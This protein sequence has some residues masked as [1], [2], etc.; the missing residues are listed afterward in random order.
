[1]NKEQLCAFVAQLELR[2]YLETVYTELDQQGYQ[3]SK[4]DYLHIVIHFINK[5]VEVDTSR[6]DSALSNLQRTI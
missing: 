1:M 4:Y 5:Y 2:K 3:D 6:L